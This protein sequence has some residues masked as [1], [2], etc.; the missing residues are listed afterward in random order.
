MKPTFAP[1]S[2]GHEDSLVRMLTRRYK[3]LGLTFTKPERWNFDFDEETGIWTLHLPEGD[4]RFNVDVKHD[5]VQI[6]A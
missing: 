1:Y 6:L 5:M 2:H 4:F 3:K